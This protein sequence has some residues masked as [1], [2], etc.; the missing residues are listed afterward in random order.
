MMFFLF[1]NYEN[2]DRTSS[3]ECNDNKLDN[4][5]PETLYL[6]NKESLDLDVKYLVFTRR[7]V[8]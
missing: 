4:F 1:C 7:L 8:G 2:V 5:F 3:N 6:Q